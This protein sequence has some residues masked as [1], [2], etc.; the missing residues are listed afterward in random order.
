MSRYSLKSKYQSLEGHRSQA[1]HWLHGDQPTNWQFDPGTI[2]DIFLTMFLFLCWFL[3][4]EE[5]GTASWCYYELFD[6]EFSKSPLSIFVKFVCILPCTSEFSNVR[7]TVTH[8]LEWWKY[9][10]GECFNMYK[11]TFLL[12]HVYIWKE[13]LMSNIFCMKNTCAEQSQ[14]TWRNR[15]EVAA[16]RAH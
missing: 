8:S 3:E 4:A 12:W 7:N 15:H 2:R 11:W 10:W 14:Y 5:T 1:L 13:K 16:I 9:Y 6:Y